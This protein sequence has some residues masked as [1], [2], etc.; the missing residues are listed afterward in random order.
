MK[1]K[2]APKKPARFVV[3][4]STVTQLQRY[5]PKPKKK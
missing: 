1:P 5:V 4:H 3:E 2:P